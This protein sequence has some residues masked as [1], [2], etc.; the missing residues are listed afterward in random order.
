MGL[1]EV[2]IGQC[3]ADT[4]IYSGLLLMVLKIDLDKSVGLQLGLVPGCRL[5]L[6]I[7]L[8]MDVRRDENVLR[9]IRVAVPSCHGYFL[10]I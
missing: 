6:Q 7:S 8:R 3:Y 5:Q 10:Y 4:S 9:S 2:S 1:A